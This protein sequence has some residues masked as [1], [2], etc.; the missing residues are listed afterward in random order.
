MIVANVPHMW[1]VIS[2]IFRVGSF[3]GTSQQNTR[4][5]EPRYASRT[6]RQHKN[7]FATTLSEE[8]INSEDIDIID[9]KYSGNSQDFILEERGKTT[10][11]IESDWK[12]DFSDDSGEQVQEV[13]VKSADP[14][15]GYIFQTVEV[16][17][18]VQNA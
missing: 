17:Q 12:T 15:H 4:G 5:D 16:K 14:E 18:S 9:T 6:P 3:N 10:T 2:R 8:R 7:Q 11:K 13:K 1:P